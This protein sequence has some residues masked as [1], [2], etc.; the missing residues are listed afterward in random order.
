MDTVRLWLIR[1]DQPADLL[2]RLAA[3]LDA[4]ERA[5]AA[6]RARPGDG[7]FIAAHGAARAILGDRL[8]LPPGRIHWERGRHGKPEL[9]GQ[10]G[11]RVNLSHSGRFAVLAVTDRRPVGVD[12]QHRRSD[13]DVARM[14]ARF[15]PPAEAGYVAAGGAPADRHRRF[16][17]LWV[18]KEACVKAAGG[19]LTEGLRLPVRGTAPVL[20][21]DPGGPLPGPYLVSDLPAPA[22]Y[23]AAVAAAGD[24]PYR[25]VWHRWPPTESTSDSSDPDPMVVEH[26]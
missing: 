21:R 12:L 22:G 19:R 5:R 17:R 8:G 24:R 16:A 26:A 10:P 23:H 25:V 6:A 14:A 20:V 9:A 2:D 13:V 3:T 1:L 7:R 11:V 4:G 15:Y 18:R